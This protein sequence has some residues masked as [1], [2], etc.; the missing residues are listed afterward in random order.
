MTTKQKTKRIDTLNL[1]PAMLKALQAEH[2]YDDDVLAAA[3][4]EDIGGLTSGLRVRL[5]T[6][7]PNLRPEATSGRPNPLLDGMQD[8]PAAVAEVLRQ[9]GAGKRDAE[10][11]RVARRLSITDVVRGSDG[12]IHEGETQSYLAHLDDGGSRRRAW[13]GLDVVPLDDAL[14]RLRRNPMT[15][16]ELEDGI[17]ERS[18]VVWSELADDMLAAVSF[19]AD[20]GM[21]VGMTEQ[22]VFAAYHGGDPKLVERTI[23]RM[24][25]QRVSAE[26]ILVRLRRAPGQA[27]APVIPSGHRDAG[28]DGKP[29][30][31]Y[32][33]SIDQLYKL[34]LRCWSADELRALVTTSVA[35]G[36]RA[37]MN[38]LPG[39]TASA[40]SVAF[41]LAN[42]W[43]RRGL[44]TGDLM[45]VLTQSRPQRAGDIQQVFAGMGIY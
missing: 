6:G 23:Q 13:H 1:E 38:E 44:I 4:P 5:R 14:G 45:A 16:A 3:T 20:D 39:G 10:L 35:A 29:P 42:A 21:L 34:L 18:G 28:R 25:L 43:Q 12:K 33:G 8:R 17:D 11:R 2:L 27:E 7:F 36:G 24:R 41:E 26:D 15:K 30:T 37:I 22:G 9:F 40:D 31:R 19:A 32:T